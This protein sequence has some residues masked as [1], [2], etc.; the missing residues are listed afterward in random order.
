MQS[1]NGISW[2]FRP[3]GFEFEKVNGENCFCE[4]TQTLL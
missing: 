4:I 2:A 1:L 3:G